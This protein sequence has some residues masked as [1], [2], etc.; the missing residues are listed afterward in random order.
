MK[1]RIFFPI[2]VALIVLALGI[3]VICVI[4]IKSNAVTHLALMPVE[5]RLRNKIEFSSSTVWLP[6]G[7]FLEDMSAIDEGGRLYYCKT[8]DIKYNL[9]NLLFK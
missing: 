1:E 7:V 3:V 5:K 4:P 8:A 6:G 9:P 2:K